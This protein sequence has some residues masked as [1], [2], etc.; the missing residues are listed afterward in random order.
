MRALAFAKRNFT[1]I[2]RE[3]IK[4][5]TTHPLLGAL[6]T[7]NRIKPKRTVGS[8]ISIIALRIKTRVELEIL[9]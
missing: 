7:K 8:A 9:R 6:N 1:E 3:P 2:I 5:R 4:P